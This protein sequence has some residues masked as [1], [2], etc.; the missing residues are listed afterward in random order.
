[1]E[2]FTIEFKE[3]DGNNLPLT[4]GISVERAKEIQEEVNKLQEVH[5]PTEDETITDSLKVLLPLAKNYHEAVYLIASIG[6]GVGETMGIQR[7]QRIYAMKEA[8]EKMFL[9]VGKNG[10]GKKEEDGEDGI[11]SFFGGQA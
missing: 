11:P 9:G 10:E 8:F 7:A 3:G 5:K 1:M 2:K 6:I 4:L